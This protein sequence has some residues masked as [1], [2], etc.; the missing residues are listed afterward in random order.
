MI[1]GKETEGQG[2]HDESFGHFPLSLP[3][4]VSFPSL[5]HCH[6]LDL[7]IPYT[8]LFP[9]IEGDKCRGNRRVGTWKRR[10][11]RWKRE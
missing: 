6:S 4:S 2:K 11:D 8:R 3:L 7:P 1:V 9:T 10:V 5:C